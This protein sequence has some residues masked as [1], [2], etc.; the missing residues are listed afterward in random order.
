VRRRRDEPELSP[1][2]LGFFRRALS[3]SVRNGFHAVRLS[4]EGGIPELGDDPA[5]IYLNH[6]SWWDPLLCLVLA[7][8]L[9]PERPHFAPIEATM[10]E[11]Y[12]FMKKI[13]FFGVEKSPAGARDFVRVSRSLLAR[14][15][16]MLW[17]TPTGRFVDPRQRDVTFEGG[18]AF[19]AREM[20]GG[21]LVPLALELPF[22]KERTPEALCRL[23]TPIPAKKEGRTR[24]EWSRL[25]EERLVETQEALAREAM[26]QDPRRFTTL[27]TGTVGVG[28]MYDLF[29]KL[30]A[31]IRGEQFRAAHSD[32]EA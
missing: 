10:L 7:H 23:G 5:V 6:P 4:Q 16:A 27:K 19:L 17:I 22:W 31:W 12:R 25:L 30:R 20:E 14:D 29:R 21:H 32:E 11:R 3:R 8:S 18:L 2:L 13:G 15:R 9:W 24:E 28:G 1:F 26:T